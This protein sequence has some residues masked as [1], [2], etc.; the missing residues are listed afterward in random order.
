M[1]VDDVS[2][3]SAQHR[4]LAVDDVST[5]S[6]QPCLLAVD[7]ISCVIAEQRNVSCRTFNM[8]D[9]IRTLWNYFTCNFLLYFLNSLS[10]TY[11]SV[12][13]IGHLSLVPLRAGSTKK[14][15]PRTLGR[16]VY[17]TLLTS[18]GSRGSPI[19]YM[20][21]GLHMTGDGMMVTCAVTGGL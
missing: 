11:L 8:F 16:H 20:C 19:V 3:Y 12:A 7:D 5:Y 18:D 13:E 6:A 9:V 21:L 1:A 17:R 14:L 2:T 15:Y 10:S 4:L